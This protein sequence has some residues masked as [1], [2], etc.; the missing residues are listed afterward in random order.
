M[1][2]AVQAGVGQIDLILRSLIF[3]D[4]DDERANGFGLDG[5]R[6]NTQKF[7]V[8]GDR[9]LKFLLS[10]VDA[11]KQLVDHHR[12]GSTGKLFNG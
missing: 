12:V 2:S 8:S 5:I 6:E 10:F 11:S 4:L 3:F 9:I 1:G 7:L